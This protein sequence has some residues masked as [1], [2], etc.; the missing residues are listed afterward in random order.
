MATNVLSDTLTGIGRSCRTV[1]L[2]F[3]AGVSRKTGFDHLEGRVAALPT[4]D[5]AVL[6]G[7]TLAFLF[8]L[9]LF[10]AQFGLVGLALYLLAIVLIVG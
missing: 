2:T 1:A 8:G 10:A 9:S 4:R 6:V 3:I 7:A 5:Q